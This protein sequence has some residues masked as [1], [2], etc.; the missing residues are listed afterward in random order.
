MSSVALASLGF[1][2][3]RSLA[4]SRE[5]GRIGSQRQVVCPH[6]DFAGQVVEQ[7]PAS[8]IIPILNGDWAIFAIS[9]MAL[10]PVG[11]AS[12]TVTSTSTG[13]SAVEGARATRTFIFPVARSIDA[14][15]RSFFPS[16]IALIAF[17][18]SWIAATASWSMVLCLLFGF[19]PL[20]FDFRPAAAWLA[21]VMPPKCRPFPPHELPQR[22]PGIQAS[23]I[24]SGE[25]M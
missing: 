19:L 18:V 21:T 9:R 14:M 24:T 25:L 5:A 7:Y 8:G 2:S 10:T 3:S 15:A 6:A 16:A 20:S 4:A 22:T 12:I 1:L 11:A 13:I 23:W 17:S